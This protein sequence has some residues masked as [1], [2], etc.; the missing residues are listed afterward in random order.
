MIDWW[1]VG[2][3]GLWVAGLAIFL[4]ALSY[5]RA[6]R[7]HGAPGQALLWSGEVWPALG[8]A[9]FCLGMGLVS[10]RWWKLLLWLALFFLALCQPFISRWLAQRRAVR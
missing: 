6:A 2:V 8:L 1:S 4:A 5:H 3:N 9:L 10:D 7:A